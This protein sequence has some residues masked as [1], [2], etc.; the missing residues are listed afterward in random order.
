VTTRKWQQPNAH[1]TATGKAASRLTS[2]APTPAS[3]PAS[4]RTV[5][6]LYDLRGDK[7]SALR[8]YF[9]T[10]KLIDQLTS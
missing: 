2:P 4:R 8:I 9:P 10:S 6:V 5:R 1:R 7:V 3:S